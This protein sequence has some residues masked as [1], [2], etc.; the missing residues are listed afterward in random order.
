MFHFSS[1]TRPAK[2]QAQVIDRLVDGA[3]LLIHLPSGDYYSLDEVGSRIWQA[4]DGSCT[5]AQIAEL[6]SAEYAVDRDKA[7]TDVLHL[8][9]ELAEAGLVLAV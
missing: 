9:E 6:I 2:N 3:V 1:D 5:A 7:M 8:V 4:I